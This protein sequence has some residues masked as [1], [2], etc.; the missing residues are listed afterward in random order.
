[1]KERV[2]AAVLAQQRLHFFALGNVQRSFAPG[3]LLIHVP[4]LLDARQI[5]FEHA[6]LH[7][8]NERVFAEVFAQ[9]CLHFFFFGPVERR[10][11]TQRN[12]I[13]GRLAGE[14]QGHDILVIPPRCLVTL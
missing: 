10:L 3:I 2:F 14:Q 4:T 5:L 13:D 6:A 1:M 8:L 9:Q 7:S 11:A 12:S